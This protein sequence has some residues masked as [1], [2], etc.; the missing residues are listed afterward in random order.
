MGSSWYVY[1][2][3]TE[4][5][6]LYTGISTDIDRRFSE[7]LARHL[8][9]GNKGAKYFLGRRP[10]AVVFREQCADRAEASRREYRLKA[11]SAA[12]KRRL[13]DSATSN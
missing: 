8:G 1:M 4:C 11:L 10:C 13:I 9:Q 5:K 2:I 3:E 7:H 6:C 12:A